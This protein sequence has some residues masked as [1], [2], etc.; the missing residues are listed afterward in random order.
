MALV[1]GSTSR[2][3]HQIQHNPDS[4]NTAA[5]KTIAADADHS[6]VIARILFSYDDDGAGSLTITDGTDT[7]KC[8]VTKGGAGPIGD[9]DSPV[10][11]G[12]KGAAVIIT[13]AAVTSVK[14]TVNI[15]YY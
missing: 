13:L 5:T 14:G 7:W 10:F 3:Y 2:T 1:P 6:W 4:D 15:L 12:A 9:G 8:F 11:I